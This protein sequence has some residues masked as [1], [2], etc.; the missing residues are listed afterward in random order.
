MIIKSPSP[1]VEIPDISWPE[2]FFK[3]IEPYHKQIALI[4]GDSGRQVN[5]DELKKNIYL[6]ARSLQKKGYKK[7]DVFAIYAPNIIE[8]IYVFQSVM[9][10]GGVITTANPLYTAGELELQLQHS[11]AICLFTTADLLEKVNPILQATSVDEVFVFN[12][13]DADNSFD[14]LLQDNKDTEL[15]PVSIDARTDIAILPYSSGTTGL[16]KGVMLSHRNLV[17]HNIQIEAQQ[18]V[19][20]PGTEDNMIA[21]LPFFHIYGITVIMNLGLCNGTSLII[22]NGFK[23]EQFLGLIQ[24]H[25]ITTAYLVPPIIL[26]LANHPLV[27]NFDM[28]SLQYIMSGAAP[29]GSEQLQAV[30]KRIRCTVHQGYGLT[31][32]S[33]VVIKEPDLL[34]S[35]KQG[36]VGVLMPNTEA[37]IIDTETGEPLR[38]NQT[39]ELLLRG[40]QIMTGYLN[41]SQATAA[42]IDA[43]GWLHSGDIARV[44]EDGYFY[45]VDRLKELIKCKGYPVAPA[46]LEALLLTHPAI[47]DAAV[48]PKADAKAGEV[49]KAFIVLKQEIS[50]DEIIAW[51]EDKVASYKQIKA[52]E[53][54]DQIP[55]SPSGKI[56]RWVLRDCEG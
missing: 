51:T 31:E 17:A 9:L 33:P 12:N 20:Y 13:G 3:R 28:S 22:V 23:P 4:D 16:P 1:S 38:F 35:T 21:V 54:I 29:I 25:R 53:F 45:I 48:V 52:I 50:A 26:F 40:P 41:N 15:Q 11:K 5:Y 10:I 36:T 44:D 24:Q 8:Y 46:E 19:T 14:L 42:T 34:T 43:D 55:K 18:D 7:G 37:M 6:V 30:S 47:V 32:T 27:S 49:P 2:Y 56:L 39:G